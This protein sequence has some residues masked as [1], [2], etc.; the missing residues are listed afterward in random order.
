MTGC[1]NLMTVNEIDI[2][3]KIVN[4]HRERTHPSSHKIDGHTFV[5]YP[6]VFSPLIAPSGKITLEFAKMSSIL[7]G[8]NVLEI[9]CG[10]G[11]PSCLFAINGAK[12]V[13][14][15]DISSSAIKNSNENC[16]NLILS[17]QVEFYQSTIES[18]RH[19]NQFD[20]IYADLPFL[21]GDPQDNLDRAFYD[22][23]LSSIQK[24]LTVFH[25]ED[26]FI[27]SSLYLCLSDFGSP[28]ILETTRAIGLNCRL[29]LHTVSDEIPLNLYEITH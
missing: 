8:K 24:L 26:R 5:V 6:D 22:K 29:I 23:N 11:I 13:V 28:L 9:G 19:H 2:A 17:G 27:E 7:K 10:S 21:D 1:D 12:T 4:L 16:R 18:M 14:G 3:Q 25:L 20:V 15:I